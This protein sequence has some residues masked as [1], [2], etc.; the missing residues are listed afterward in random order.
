MEL[1]LVIATWNVPN[2]TA[3]AMEIL[4]SLAA[5]E[6]D[7]NASMIDFYEKNEEIIKAKIK[8]IRADAIQSKI[9][10]LDAEYRNL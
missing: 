1:P 7:D 4:Q 5:A 6:W 3:K 9:E 2:A 8:A 10:A